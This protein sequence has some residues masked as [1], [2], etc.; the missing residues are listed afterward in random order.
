MKQT[1]TV[2][3]ALSAIFISTPLI[4]SD[5]DK[6][7][8]AA[9]QQTKFK[10]FGDEE[11]I[12]ISS[13]PEITKTEQF[14]GF[15]NLKYLGTIPKTNYQIECH[16]FRFIGEEITCCIGKQA[17]DHLWSLSTKHPGR[18]EPVSKEVWKFYPLPSSVFATIEAT[19]KL[20]EARKAEKKAE[21]KK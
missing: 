1:N 2:L 8:S 18:L 15:Q 12:D 21:G 5:M 19:Y 17:R 4:C 20:Q 6:K 9:H 10:P 14:N 16:K 13:I 7:K 11:E 3:L